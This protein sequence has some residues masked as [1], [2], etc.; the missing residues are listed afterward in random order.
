MTHIFNPH[1]VYIGASGDGH[2]VK[3][4]MERGDINGEG[5]HRRVEPLE[6]LI[7]IRGIDYLARTTERVARLEVNA[8][9]VEEEE[10]KRGLLPNSIEECINEGKVLGGELL[11]SALHYGLHCLATQFRIFSAIWRQRTWSEAVEDFIVYLEEQ[12]HLIDTKA[13]VFVGGR[14]IEKPRAGGL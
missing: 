4:T 12:R 5:E 2:M 3:L 7:T 1:C 14:V 6:V 9:P 13:S 11:L 10:T 8:S